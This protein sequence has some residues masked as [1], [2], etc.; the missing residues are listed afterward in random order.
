MSAVYPYVHVEKVA[1]QIISKPGVAGKIAVVGSFDTESTSPAYYNNLTDAQEA[2]GTDTTLNGCKCLP[3]LF[4]GASGIVAINTGS[5]PLTT[6][7]LSSALAKIKHEDFDLLFV[8]EEMTDAFIPI[9]ATF[10]AEIYEFKNPA[11][12]VLALNRANKEAYEATKE[13]LGN[14]IIGTVSQQFII[15]NET[16]DLIESAAYYTGMI[17]GSNVANSMTRKNVP[18]MTGLVNEYTY[19]TGD[20]GLWLVENGFTCF[21]CINREEDVYQVVNSEQPNGYDLYMIR[22]ENYIIKLFNL[23]R[24]LGEKTKPKTIDEV[25]QEIDRIRDYC[26]NSLDLVN[27]IT[28]TI[29]KAGAECVEIKLDSIKFPGVITKINMLIR[30]EVE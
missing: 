17:A 18:D 23:I 19:E 3:K 27:D 22:A 4:Y 25:T 28:Y 13:L 8:A 6:E 10:L 12:Y 24:F 7:T 21:E 5:E 11:S 26:I 1:A 20:L 15:N 29:R 30:V 2:L 16:Y 9:V 14:F